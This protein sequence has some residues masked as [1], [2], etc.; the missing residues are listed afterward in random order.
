MPLESSCFR[1][2]ASVPPS[3]Q[4]KPHAAV[5]AC[6][7]ALMTFVAGTTESVAGIIPVQSYS[8]VNGS[9]TANWG[10]Y[11]YF[12]TAYSGS[13]DKTPKAQSLTATALPSRTLPLC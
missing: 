9:G 11:D 3:M 5:A 12:D 1:S 7:L 8:M 2:H 4:I 6:V 10:T 13:G